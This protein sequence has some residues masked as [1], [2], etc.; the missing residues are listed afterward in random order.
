MA[1]KIKNLVASNGTYRNAAGEEKSR[2]LTVGGMFQDGNK[3][4]IKIDSIPA[5]KEWNGWLSIVDLPVP[6][7][8]PQPSRQ[9]PRQG[10]QR[11]QFEGM[12][13]DIPF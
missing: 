10:Q 3:T 6:D 12:D 11:S 9:A 1:T 8:R 2:W 7:E 13:D 5:G 4:T